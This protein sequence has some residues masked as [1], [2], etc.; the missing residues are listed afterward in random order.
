LDGS[1]SNFYG[2]SRAREL[3]LKRASPTPQDCVGVV[4]TG[5]IVV[6]GRQLKGPRLPARLVMFHLWMTQAQL[7]VT[8]ILSP[9]TR[10]AV[11]GGDDDESDDEESED[12]KSCLR[13]LFVGL[14]IG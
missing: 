13:G 10:A 8:L 14:V 11:A 6:G 4:S 2:S 7:V 3:S 1:G 5:I 12:Q 9:A